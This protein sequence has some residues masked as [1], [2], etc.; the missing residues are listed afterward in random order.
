MIKF[1]LKKALL[2]L[3]VQQKMIRTNFRYAF[4]LF[5]LLIATNVQAQERYFAEVG[6]LGGG[7]FYLG[8]ANKIPFTH[9]DATYGGFVKYKLDKRYSFG[10]QAAAG[11]VRI[12]AYENFAAHKTSFVDVEAIA[13]FNFFDF[14]FDRRNSLT[15]RATPYIFAGVGCVIYSAKGDAAVTLPFGIG[16]KFKLSEQ[17][18]LGITWSMSKVF[19]DNFDDIDNPRGLN[20]LGLINNDWYSKFTVYLSFDFWQYCRTCH[21]GLRK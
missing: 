13:E 3:V 18:N 4:F 6:I 12:P 16:G 14:G 15:K 2:Q 17:W 9:L 11:K 20:K 7:T 19:K 21:S 10:L 1:L 5:S 8:D